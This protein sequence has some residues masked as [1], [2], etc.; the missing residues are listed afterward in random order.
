M[1]TLAFG[2]GIGEHGTEV[3][4]EIITKLAKYLPIEL[5]VQA[6]KNASRAK[7]GQHHLITTKNSRIQAYVCKVDEAAI[8]LRDALKLV[9]PHG[10]KSQL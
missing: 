5:D 1:D 10:K 6:N 8:M 4:E 9:Q 7:Q 2:G 3:R